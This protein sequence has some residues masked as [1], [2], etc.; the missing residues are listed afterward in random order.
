MGCARSAMEKEQDT[1][2]APAEDPAD[3]KAKGSAARNAR[4]R[5]GA[6][7]PATTEA[8]QAVKRAAAA[9]GQGEPAPSRPA[10]RRTTSAAQKRD[11]RIVQA[12]L[13]ILVDGA[14]QSPVVDGDRLTARL[15]RL[16]TGELDRLASLVAGA[17]DRKGGP[18]RPPGAFVDELDGRL[19]ERGIK[20][21]VEGD[22]NTVNVSIGNSTQT[23]ERGK[24]GAFK[25]WQDRASGKWVNRMPRNSWGRQLARVRG[26]LDGR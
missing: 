1:G 2:P 14:E 6:P 5:H 24:D 8:R 18:P 22:G 25:P 15:D 9:R 16:T 11:E 10:G 26:F 19:A 13:G 7:Q 21:N 17:R 20:V 4:R 23:Q 12:A 3:T